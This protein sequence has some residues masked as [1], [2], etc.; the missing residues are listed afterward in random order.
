MRVLLCALGLAVASAAGSSVL[1]EGPPDSG[2]PGVAITYDGNSLAV[3]G[4]C[5]S[6]LCE[7]NAKAAATNGGSVT[8]LE[9]AVVAED[10][11][12]GAALGLE[13][14]TRQSS[15]KDIR[16]LVLKED[17]A[18]QAADA[19]LRAALVSEEAARNA[20][21]ANLRAEI[22]ALKAR[23]TALASSLA[24]VVKRLDAIEKTQTADVTALTEADAQAQRELA[25]LAEE[26]RRKDKEVESAI[27]SVQAQ[28]KDDI[29]R[30]GKA[31]ASFVAADT[32]IEKVVEVL[33][34]QSKRADADL[35]QQI[36]LVEQQ[37][38]QDVLELKKRDVAIAQSSSEGDAELTASHEGTQDSLTNLAAE[39]RKADAELRDAISA[40]SKMKGPKGEAGAK[41]AT[42]ATGAKGET[43]ATGEAGKAGAKGEVGAAGQKGEKGR[44]APTPAPPTPAPPTPAPVWGLTAEHA[45]A[46]CADLQ[47]KGVSTP[48]MYY[49]RSPP[50]YGHG[51]VTKGGADGYTGGYAGIDDVNSYAGM[52]F[53]PNHPLLGKAIA[54]ADVSLKRD[55]GATGEVQLVLLDSKYALKATIGSVQ[56]SSLGETTPGGGGTGPAG[57]EAWTLTKFRMPAG[58]TATIAAND[59]LALHSASGLSYYDH[60]RVYYP[61]VKNSKLGFDQNA[62]IAVK[63]W[64]AWYPEPRADLKITI[65]ASGF[66]AVKQVQCSFAR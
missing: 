18:R 32:K 27:A 60:K 15:D 4:Y 54:G 31:D 22:A 20:T 64:S 59:V 14:Y 6:A 52:V 29:E 5:R 43:G 51:S 17:A 39:S 38:A 16:E 37:Q 65:W 40:V 12:L 7:A 45:G 56:A 10:A 28:H 66:D 26:S 36:D 58:T 11:K 3:P 47:A 53:D 13:S 55:P 30:L 41:G 19:T 61:E 50:L 63:H 46:S 23:N 44:D 33:E 9:A 24:A 49:V 1:F 62:E 8:A 34:E 48:G 42:G 25:A 21:D 2:T 35:Q 57:M